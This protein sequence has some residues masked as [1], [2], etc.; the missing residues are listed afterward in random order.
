MKNRKPQICKS[1]AELLKRC[2]R[3]EM[4]LGVDPVIFT[5]L[6]TKL[7]ES[8][9]VSDAKLSPEVVALNR[10]IEIEYCDDGERALCR[11]VLPA[12]A[13]NQPENISVLTPLGL[14]LL[15]RHVGET[16]SWPLAVGRGELQVNIIN[17][18]VSEPEMAA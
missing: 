2:F 8:S 13:K 18:D 16:I 3:G 5:K 6:K 10:T 15:G 1:D 4:T 7:D 9:I 14:A 17:V 12:D 11:L